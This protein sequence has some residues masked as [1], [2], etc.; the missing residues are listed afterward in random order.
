MTGPTA[1]GKTALALQFAA[2]QGLE[3]LSMDS[4]AVYRHMDI[5]T[6][7]PTAAERAAVPH[8]LLDLVEPSESFDTAR[9]CE[10]AAAALQDVQRRGRRA[11]FVG[12]TPLYLMAFFKGLMQ[13]PPADAELRAA[14]EDRERAE[15]GCLHAELQHL[16]P[17]AA[18]RIHRHDL[19]R[20]VRAHEVLQLTGKPIS[21]QQQHFD[22]EEWQ[23]PC[24]IVA[25]QRQ[26][27]DLHERVKARTEWMLDAG[28][29]AETERI[30]Q[31]GGF[32]VTA[33]AAIGYAE[34]RDFLRGRYKDREELRNRIRRNTHRLIRRQTTWLRRL[35]Q[36][37]W[38]EPD[39]GT[40]ALHAALQADA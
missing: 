7:K 28:L 11:L 32:S 14:L 25:V 24:R 36:A 8:H 39:A 37:R 9:W 20:L 22:R 40:A 33:G 2:E 10:A 29:L 30:E 1:S 3:I 35:Q 38:L 27:D 15:P 18:A 21:S 17:D 12:G 5:G 23:R 13:T 16:D 31:Q 19:R 26:R 6:A 34:C 4:M